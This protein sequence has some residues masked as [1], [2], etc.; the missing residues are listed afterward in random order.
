M[1]RPEPRT[2]V[3]R[4]PRTRSGRRR[5][6]H[7]GPEAPAGPDRALRCQERVPQGHPQLRRREPPRPR[8]EA[9]RGRRRV[10]P[11]QR[12]GVTVLRRRRLRRRGIG[13]QRFRGSSH[14]AGQGDLR[15]P[16]RVR[17]RSRC[18]GRRSHHLLHQHL[19]PVGDAGR[20]AAGPQRR[21]ERPVGQAV[22]QDLDGAR[23]PGGQRLLRQ[24]RPVAVPGEAGLLSR[25]I[26]L[27][28]VHRQHRSAAGGDLQGRQRRRPHRDRGAVGQP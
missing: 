9:R 26:R 2:R 8:D 15:R 3:L 28:H 17:P 12:L 1:A 27:H 7:R 11:G 21:R 25:R 5:A 20:G 23:L 18:G 16:R 24:G 6:V 13:G 4:V 19:Q 22:G 14:Q 10:V